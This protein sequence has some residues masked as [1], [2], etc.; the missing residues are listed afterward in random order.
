MQEKQLTVVVSQFGNEDPAAAVD[1]REAAVPLPGKGEV[2]CRL[3]LR[4]VNPKI[5]RAHV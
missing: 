4:P 1:L 2:L 5:G 3:I